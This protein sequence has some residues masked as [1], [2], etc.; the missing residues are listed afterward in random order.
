MLCYRH[1]RNSQVP[2]S[3]KKELVIALA[4]SFSRHAVNRWNG[5]HYNHNHLDF[6]H[7]LWMLQSW[8]W[9]FKEMIAV[10]S[11]NAL[12]HDFWMCANF[13]QISCNFV[14]FYKASVEWFSEVHFGPTMLVN[15]VKTGLYA[16]RLKPLNTHFRMMTSWKFGRIIYSLWIY[17]AAPISEP[18]Y[19]IQSTWTVDRPT[20]IT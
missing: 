9:I 2:W 16:S 13:V 7:S 12:R 15:W 3:I 19:S 17:R 20:I 18:K 14:L 11:I 6:N 5:N 10:S 1:F 8:M 4:Y